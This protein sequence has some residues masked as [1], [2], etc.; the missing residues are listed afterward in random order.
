MKF[1]SEN[2]LK[3]IVV[4][5]LTGCQRECNYR[6][7]GKVMF[8]QTSVSLSTIGLMPTQSLLI[9]VGYSVTCYGAVGTHPTRMLTCCLF[10]SREL[11]FH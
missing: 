4:H 11:L 7:Q 10:I 2:D 5:M 9:L 6:P 3:L 1:P 8:S